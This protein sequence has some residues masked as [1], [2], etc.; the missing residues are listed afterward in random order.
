MSSITWKYLKNWRK[1]SADWKK[2]VEDQQKVLKEARRNIQLLENL[3]E[4]FVEI[5]KELLQHQEQAEIDEIA[6]LFHKR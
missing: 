2:K 1:S 6:V 3:K 5:V 4:K